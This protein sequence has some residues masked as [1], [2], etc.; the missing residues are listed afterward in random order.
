MRTE[1]RTENRGPDRRVKARR[2]EEK[3]AAQKSLV[4]ELV[5]VVEAG[6]RANLASERRQD[7]PRPVS[8]HRVNYVVDLLE[9]VSRV[10]LSNAITDARATG[11]LI[12]YSLGGTTDGN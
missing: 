6:A 2:T 9:E 7:D 1:R 5:K 11:A 12:E 8:L 4:A 3:R 10:C